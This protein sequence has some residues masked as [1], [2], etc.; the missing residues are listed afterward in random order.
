MAARPHPFVEP[1]A[2]QGAISNLPSKIKQGSHKGMDSEMASRPRAA[3]R[4][5]PAAAAF[6]L[7]AATACAEGGHYGE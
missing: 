1:R 7:L 4:L 6:L 2:H 3:P 5:L